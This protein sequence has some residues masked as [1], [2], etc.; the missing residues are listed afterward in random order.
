MPLSTG[1]RTSF[2]Q[3]ILDRQKQLSGGNKSYKISP[4]EYNKAAV[5]FFGKIEDQLPQG[6]KITRTI[7][8]LEVEYELNGKT[9][10][11]FR[12]T[13]SNL[14]IN[15][16][17][18]QT[19]Q[20]GSLIDSQSAAG[21]QD[22]LKQL[23]PQLFG[24]SAQQGQQ[25][26]LNARTDGAIRTGSGGVG[27]SDITTLDPRGN[28][29]WLDKLMG[30]ANRLANRQGFVPIDPATQQLLDTLTAN[31]RGQ[32][33]QQFNDQSSQLVADLYGRGV[34]RSSIAGDQAN[35]L[36]QGQGL[37]GAQAEAD[38]AARALQVLQFLTQAEQGNLA[39]A[40][41]QY[42]SGAQ[43]AQSDKTDLRNFA[44]RLLDQALSRETSG[45]QL[46]QSQQQIDNN[47]SQ[48][49]QNY[50]LQRDQFEAQAAQQ[51][52]A[53]RLQMISSVL[54]G[55]LGL[56]SSLIGGGALKGLGSVFG[57]GGGAGAPPVGGDGGYG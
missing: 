10:K 3:F 23:L 42:T 20:L 6:A 1:A 12:N 17:R 15:T 18:V 32:L 35:K 54:N 14:G 48:F 46:N 5:E 45:I 9:Y 30:N 4:E 7:S 22:L 2:E 47:M 11:A 19:T 37:V 38:A 39:L 49:E 27:G 21:E 50:G 29:S 53:N 33:N 57:G 16:G 25:S 28:I 52:R 43:Q 8:P 24:T 56:G 40:G 34:N 55:V 44:L 36:L 41:E 31:T 13:D 51:R 26:Q